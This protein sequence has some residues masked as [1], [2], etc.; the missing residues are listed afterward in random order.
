MKLLYILLAFLIGVLVP[1]QAI[2]N[3]RLANFI[4]SNITA[5]FISFTGGFLIFLTIVMLSPAPFPTWS[6]LSSLPP[7]AYIGG[8]I[9]SVFVLSAIILVPKLGST[10]FVGL[11]VA[12]QLCISLILDHF[13][14]LGLPVN[15]VGMARIFGAILLACGATL[16]LN[17]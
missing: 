1:F 2:V 16:I 4:Q 6:K 15:P 12:G 8:I 9:G 3:S 13:G 5:A 10:G 7:Y 11:V 14:F 17:Y